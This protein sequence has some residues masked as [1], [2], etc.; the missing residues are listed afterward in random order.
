MVSTID[1]P[2]SPWLV[3][4]AKEGS[5]AVFI[6][7]LGEYCKTWFKILNQPLLNMVNLNLNTSSIHITTNTKILSCSISF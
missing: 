5:T 2:K 1:V 4:A 6:A 7:I 3:E